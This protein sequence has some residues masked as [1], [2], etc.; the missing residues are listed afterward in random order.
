MNDT[1]RFN[2]VSIPRSQMK[3]SSSRQHT[4]NNKTSNNM[5]L[6]ILPILAIETTAQACSAAVAVDG[7]VAASQFQEMSS[8]QS[9]ALFPMI[10]EGQFLLSYNDYF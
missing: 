10:F 5:N 3:R 6:K 1:L 2:G 7:V 9:E 8:G 4:D